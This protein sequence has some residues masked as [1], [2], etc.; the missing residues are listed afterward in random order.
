MP[1][2][3]DDPANPG[4]P[5]DV[6]ELQ[7][8]D[9]QKDL[10]PY[11]LPEWMKRDTWSRREALMMLAGYNPSVTQW[12]E[13]SSGF[14]QFPAGNRGYLDGMSDWMI[15]HANVHWR[16]PRHDDAYKQFLTLSDYAQGGSLDERKTPDEW[17]A[18]ARSKQFEPYWLTSDSGNSAAPTPKPKLQQ[19]HQEDE[20]MRVISELHL[21]PKQLPKKVQGES[22]VKKQVRDKL[23]FSPAVF[24]KAWDRLRAS[25]D[26]QDI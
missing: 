4:E 20:I 1:F 17:V 6:I 25:N 8:R 24:D 15:Q 26:I 13:T 12:N 11:L 5:I 16:H 14:G 2:Y 3:V 23:N 9:T 19:R 22:G 21:D 18:W 7:K 10:Q